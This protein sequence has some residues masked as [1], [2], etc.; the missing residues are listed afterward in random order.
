MRT[1]FT[2]IAAIFGLVAFGF[3]VACSTK[4]SSSSNGLIV[5]PSNGYGVMETFSLDLSNGHVS[6]INNV[7][8]PPTLGVPGAVI[9]D[10]A[11]AFA[12]VATTENCVPPNLPANSSLTAVQGAIVTYQIGSDGKL[13]AGSTNYVKG[14]PA[15]PST[16]PTC[17]LDDATNPNG[18]NQ[19]SAM[20]ID[21]TGKFLFAATTQTTATYTI[22]LNTT[23]ISTVATLNSVGIAVYAIGSNASLTEVPGSPFSLPAEPGGGGSPSASALAVTPTFYPVQFAP[24]STFAP[25][26]FIAPATEYLYVTDSVNNVVLNYS[27]S[28][29]GALALVPFST[30]SAGATTGTAP[31]GVAVDPCNRFV[32]VSNAT[33]NSVSAYTICNAVSQSCQVPNYSLQEV[34]GSPY[35]AGDGPGPIAVYPFGNF[36]YVVDTG[37][38]QL[39]GYRVS[40]S[41]GSLTVLAASPVATNLGANAIAIRNDGNWIFVSNFTSSNVSQYAITPATG[42]LTSISPFITLNNPTGIAVK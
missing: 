8:G 37:S 17:G 4:Y 15:Y 39:S 16:F 21:S 19:V 42:T 1:R 38:S 5:V 22:D 36:V 6:Q 2:W 11:G 26:T 35:P 23:P 40:P 41:N 9:L 24:C 33:S 14:N 27:V 28:S 30:A 7:N 13:A 29:S 10:P 3:L 12:Y 31:A 20:A 32:F 18:G 34:S 25:P